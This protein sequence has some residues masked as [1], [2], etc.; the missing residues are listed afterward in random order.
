M[1][2]HSRLNDQPSKAKAGFRKKPAPAPGAAGKAAEITK[3]PIFE[4]KS[5]NFGIG[6]LHFCLTKSSTNR[7]H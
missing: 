1:L 5:K 3:N 7:F 2:I 6:L 4:A